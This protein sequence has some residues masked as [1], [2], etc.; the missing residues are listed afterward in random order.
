MPN[1]R[2]VNE[3]NETLLAH[4]WNCLIYGILASRISV[5][6]LLSVVS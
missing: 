1:G 3:T 4:V 2:V 5:F 6:E